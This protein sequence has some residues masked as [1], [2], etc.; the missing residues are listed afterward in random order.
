MIVAT[1]GHI[2]HGKTLLI[3]ALTG[4]DT[5][6]LPEEKRRGLT[7]DLGFA[8][9]PDSASGTIGF[10]D[11]PGHERFIHNMLCG[12]AGIDAALFVVAADDGPMPQTLEHLAILDLLGVRH[13]LVALTK[14]DRVPAQ[15]A[16]TVRTEIERL[17]ARTTLRGA[18]VFPVSAVTGE[19]IDALARELRRIAA[20]LPRR[21]SDGNFRLAVDRAFTVPGAGLVVTGTVFS[22]EVA[23]GDSVHALLAGV[24]GR[25]RT[26]H[27]QSAQAERGRAGE[28]C[29][30][31]LVGTGLKSDEI[32][33]GDWIVRGTLPP[34]MRR[35]DARIRVMDAEPRALKHWT[36]VHVHLGAA[37]TTARIAT[38]EAD[39]IA[40]GESGLAQLVLEHPVGAVH[41][42]RLVI[43]DQS[44]RR[45]IGGGRVID[46]YPPPRGRAKPERLETLRAMEAPDPVQ[47][48]T[49]RLAASAKSAG[50]LDLAQFADCRNLAD[51]EARTLFEVVPMKRV[52]SGAG[53]LGFLPEQWE[54]LRARAL[55]TVAGW[56]RR[57]P[58][59]PGPPEDRVLEG[60]RAPRAVVAAIAAELVREGALVRTGAEVRLP[61]HR[62]TF[63]PADEAL[64]KRIVVVLEAE[65][66][67]PP[68][69][70]EIAERVGATPKV[71]LAVLDRVARRGLAVR[72]S[73]TR[74]FLPRTVARLAGIAQ[75][76]A[77]SSAGRRITAAQFRDASGLG[78][79]VSI[80]VLDYFDRVRFTRRVG[81][82]RT[83][84]RAAAEAFDGSGARPR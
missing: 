56:H 84:L 33:R 12:V 11:V 75:T 83:L 77:A 24:D 50:G 39:A 10:I 48:L 58:D 14:I 57:L 81:D 43:R 4:V 16:A 40:P 51:D 60:A 80:D 6:R 8:Y 45:T 46:V 37:E 26:I 64:W 47:A 38:L 32:R 22:G 23:A 72:V 59:S 25:V 18:S 17:V 52:T 71:V 66:R 36:P 53:E 68:T 65:E 42:D 70:A 31:N 74:F 82:A 79:N 20:G 3:K 76:L 7:I 5:D 61:T 27:A 21:A 41:G 78:R 35:I 13:G 73:D 30:L 1:A 19:G 15:R 29:A 2:D 54:S 28:R 62:S 9:L 44:A 67:R 63:A 55:E 49:A 34:P 69:V